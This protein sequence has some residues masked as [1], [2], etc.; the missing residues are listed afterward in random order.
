MTPERLTFGPYTLTDDAL[1]RNGTP[2][3]LGGR[4][5]AILSVLARA[6]GQVVA[7]AA[8]MDQVWPGIAVEE[9]NLTVQIAA[10]RKALVHT[11][12]GQ[13]WI[14]T[15][16]R[17]GYRLAAP[18]ITAAPALPRLAVM[19]FRNLGGTATDDYFTAGVVEDI[20]TALS[21]FGSFTVVGHQPSLPHQDVGRAE[22]A[23]Q[24]QAQYILQGSVRRAGE[25]LRI[26][27]H[28][29]EAADGTQ[30][31]GA[32]FDGTHAD[33][34][35]FQDQIT[36][37]VA[38]QIAPMIEVAE[39]GRSRRERPTSLAAYDLYLRAMSLLYAET[40]QA[41]AQAI[42]L[43]DQAVALEPDNAVYLSR[44]SWALEHRITMGWTAHGP[45]DRT[46]CL[47][48]AERGLAHAHGD[49]RVMAHCAM[50][51]L[52]LGQGRDR[53]MAILDRAISLNPNN[54]LALLA[55]AVASLHIG[56]LDDAI[57]LFRRV[58]ALSPGDPMLY[59][60]YSGMGHAELAQGDPALALALA[61]Q[62]MALNP[63]FDAMLWVM[64]A[65]QVQLGRIVEARDTVAR[66]L[67]L[68]PTA[69]VAR[70]RAAQP[71]YDPQRMAA[72]LDGLRSAG[73]PEA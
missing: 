41:N 44:A 20:T 67:I 22:L 14:G 73:L 55:A 40:S 19:P 36:E 45:D 57:G 29:V 46:R 5:L 70:I 15:V 62:S 66:L 16:P 31:W 68:S 56:S 38:T 42:G 52:H 71:S 13:D 59:I 21:R 6:D 23:A 7:K 63:D 1:L 28:L 18:Q 61:T 11:P 27:A 60:A 26:A 25:Q 33:V 53:A 39:I 4:A 24:L 72:I 8:L 30:I 49:A 58:I 65:A 48:L 3:P 69:T 12:E 50:S 32:S 34:F 51:L 43:L 35:A 2:V 37:T 47:D 64:A 10:L 17:V 54:A 9:G